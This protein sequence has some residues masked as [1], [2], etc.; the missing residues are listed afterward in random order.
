MIQEVN[1]HSSIEYKIIA[2]YPS[3]EHKDKVAVLIAHPDGRQEVLYIC[4]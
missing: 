1:V 2:I 4:Q 3:I